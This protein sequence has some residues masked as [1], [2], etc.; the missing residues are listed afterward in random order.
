MTAAHLGLKYFDDI[1]YA[2]AVRVKP[3][4]QQSAM[5]CVT[6]GE[7]PGVLGEKVKS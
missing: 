3:I 7:C 6:E 5:K 2:L 1:R 4:D